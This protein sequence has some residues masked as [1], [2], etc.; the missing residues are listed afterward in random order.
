MRLQITILAVGLLAGCATTAGEPGAAPP[1]FAALALPDYDSE[2]GIAW[3][4]TREEFD[5]ARAD[6]RYE[7]L[8]FTY[9]SDSLTV[10][11]YLY[12]PRRPPGSQQPVIV[13]NRG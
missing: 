13:F 4:S 12:R 5:A 2:R 7:M 6:T 1:P 10:G 3:A 11:A 8:Q 9:P